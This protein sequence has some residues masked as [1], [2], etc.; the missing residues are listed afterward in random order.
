MIYSLQVTT[1]NL[2]ASNESITTGISVNIAGLTLPAGKK[3][4]DYRLRGFFY[5]KNA[6][7]VVAPGL[8]LR[9]SDA[10]EGIS[11]VVVDD[12]LDD[13]KPPC[14]TEIT[15]GNTEKN[16]KYCCEVLIFFSSTSN[17]ITNAS[18]KLSGQATDMA[19]FESSYSYSEESNPMV[20][21]LEEKIKTITLSSIISDGNGTEVTCSLLSP[22]GNT[23]TSEDALWIERSEARSEFR[24][25]EATGAKYMGT[26][27]VSTEPKSSV[28]TYE[29]RTQK[30]GVDSPSNRFTA[31][32]YTA[33]PMEA[34]G[35]SYTPSSEDGYAKLTLTVLPVVF[36]LGDLVTFNGIPSLQITAI[37]GNELT[38]KLPTLDGGQATTGVLQWYPRL[39]SAAV[40]VNPVKGVAFN[41]IADHR[42]TTR[43]VYAI[44]QCNTYQG[45]SGQSESE[46]LLLW[47][48]NGSDMSLASLK[49]DMIPRWA[50]S[51][52]EMWLFRRTQSAPASNYTVFT[53][54]TPSTKCTYADIW[55]KMQVPAT[56][57]DSDTIAADGSY[58][59]TESN[60]VHQLTYDVV[61][62]NVGLIEAMAKKTETPSLVIVNDKAYPGNDPTE[63]DDVDGGDEESFYPFMV[64]TQDAAV[65]ELLPSVTLEAAYHW[66]SKEDFPEMSVAVSGTTCTITFGT[67]LSN[68]FNGSAPFNTSTEN[69]FNDGDSISAIV[70]YTEANPDYDPDNPATFPYLRY[71]FRVENALITLADRQKLQFT[72]TPL[73]SS[74]TG[75]GEPY[76][77][78]A[79]YGVSV[80]RIGLV[81]EIGLAPFGQDLVFSPVPPDVGEIRYLATD[82][83]LSYEKYRA[84]IV[85]VRT[86][87]P[88]T[89]T[90]NAIDKLGQKSSSFSPQI[91]SGYK[92]ENLFNTTVGSGDRIFLNGW[93]LDETL[94]FTLSDPEYGGA[95]VA[96]NQSIAQTLSASMVT[97][98]EKRVSAILPVLQKEFKVT[99][100]EGNKVYTDDT[101]LLNSDVLI[102]FMALGDPSTS[103]PNIVNGLPKGLDYGVVYRVQTSEDTIGSFLVYSLSGN[104]VN[105][106]DMNADMCNALEVSFA[107][108][109]TPLYGSDK[110]RR[111]NLLVADLR[112]KIFLPSATLNTGATGNLVVTAISPINA[113]SADSN[114]TL[115]EVSL[116]KNDYYATIP[117]TANLNGLMSFTVSDDSGLVSLYEKPVLS[118]SIPTVVLN[119]L[120]SEPSKKTFKFNVYNPTGE[121]AGTVPAREISSTSPYAGVSVTGGDGA[122]FGVVKNCLELPDKNG[123]TF[124]V[125]V[126]DVSDGIMSVYAST[127]V[128][129]H[130]TVVRPPL[131]TSVSKQ[132]L[133]SENGQFTISGLNLDELHP[134]D[135]EDETE[136]SVFVDYDLCEPV[137]M[138]S[139]IKDILRTYSV[140]SGLPDSRY[141]FRLFKRTNSI[142][143]F[144]NS[145]TL[146]IDN[147]PPILTLL[148]ANPFYLPRGQKFVDPGC[149]VLDILSGVSVSA[150]GVQVTWSANEGVVDP[151]T[152]GNYYLEYRVT[153]LAGNSSKIIRTV[154]VQNGTSACIKIR[155][156]HGEQASMES[157]TAT[158]GDV[159]SIFAVTGHFNKVPTNNV[160]MIGNMQAKIIYGD[161]SELRCV[162]PPYVVD[163]V[164]MVSVGADGITNECVSTTPINFYAKY[165]SEDFTEERSYE[166]RM[167]EALH[168]Q[169]GYYKTDMGYYRNEPIYDEDCLIQNL[170]TVI[171]TRQGSRLFQPEYGSLIEDYLFTTAYNNNAEF[172]SSVLRYI[173]QLAD[174]WIRNPSIQI[175]LSRSYT[176]MQL[177]Q[178]AAVIVLSVILPT[179]RTRQVSLTIGDNRNA[180]T[181]RV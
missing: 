156:V 9:A 122:K 114:A 76:I 18:F 19:S 166:D 73:V 83:N 14:I 86:I 154:Q 23:F 103:N 50:F 35:V 96:K 167:Y 99:K 131:I 98:P 11:K 174:R 176:Q 53:Q 147:T 152:P 78:F 140:K 119:D 55:S 45:S 84:V 155:V 138:D 89:L 28:I 143:T 81:S 61:S 25:Y 58:F 109:V 90:M 108:V 44:D 43:L 39:P 112:P 132:Y 3:L 180:V 34:S 80:L 22:Q 72:A 41:A 146:A 107:S 163:S 133:S 151:F 124:T 70:D 4:E 71:S 179:G 91:L 40:A 102:S 63:F 137:Q 164:L 66:L 129:R 6:P 111:I 8:G 139:D 136:N 104:Q 64:L 121:G 169:Q 57:K 123:M 12:W 178:N 175:D 116:S 110:N 148:G 162:V 24:F 181:T 67:T 172:Q 51:K 62:L 54:P 92:Y 42:D 126:D 128:A 49:F 38:V 134:K 113:G 173:A 93:N 21:L 15:R 125:V 118:T 7:S 165:K 77:S 48:R 27:R 85:C 135:S 75:A 105:L 94:N 31:T 101:E 158:P 88:A 33:V 10:S 47:N 117:F 29:A 65:S 68:Y 177:D 171:L 127:E 13:I 82:S 150:G 100:V 120:D 144:G 130:S 20:W 168:P 161:T 52:A 1:S 95:G 37:S 56:R 157:I 17:T 69:P 30:P 60:T 26:Y 59:D 87:T 153:D 170:L 159:L 160:V 149:R 36:R 74:A 79:V 5:H 115:G 32:K 16:F 142:D 46:R 2:Q 145:I 97:E 141:R 106:G